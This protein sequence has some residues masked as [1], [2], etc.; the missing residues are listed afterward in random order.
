[1]EQIRSDMSK[2]RF[3]GECVFVYM[4][5]EPADFR[6]LLY[7]SND[8]GILVLGMDYRDQECLKT[9]FDRESVRNLI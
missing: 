2:F 5:T 6:L 9:R 1:M 4:N 3:E 7:Y 8:G